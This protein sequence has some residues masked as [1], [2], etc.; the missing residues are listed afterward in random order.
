MQNVS[1]NAGRGKPLPYNKNDEAIDQVRLSESL[2]RP[3]SKT[4]Y[5][6]SIS[7]TTA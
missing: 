4:S 3:E 2:S 5:E 6:Y 1:F 7:D